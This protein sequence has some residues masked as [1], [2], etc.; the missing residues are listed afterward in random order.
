M[1]KEIRCPKCKGQNLQF[2][3]NK[4]KFSV[5]KMVG[6]AVLTGGWGAVAGFI[7]KDSKKGK[8]V[9]LDC[10]KQFKK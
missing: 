2:I 7:G 8:W 3:G 9:C 1:K 5:G 4:R 10:G 6:G